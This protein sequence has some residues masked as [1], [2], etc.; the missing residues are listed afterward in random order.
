MTPFFK[1]LKW[2]VSAYVVIGGADLIER[3]AE[4][5]WGRIRAFGVWRS[6]DGRV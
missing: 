4:S 5:R 3:G 2:P 1:G 6:Q